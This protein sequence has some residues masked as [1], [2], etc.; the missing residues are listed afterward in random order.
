MTVAINGTPGAA[1]PLLDALERTRRVR[2]LVR[3]SPPAS[4][5]S[6]ACCA[7]SATISAS[8]S[9]SPASPMCARWPALTGLDRDIRDLLHYCFWRRA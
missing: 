3:R 5:A 1:N 6:A 4:H 8:S 9:P 7:P 2:Q